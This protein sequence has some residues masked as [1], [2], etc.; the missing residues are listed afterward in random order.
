MAEVID[1]CEQAKPKTRAHQALNP[2]DNSPNYS[3][4]HRRNMTANFAALR[5]CMKNPDW[6]DRQKLSDKN[7]RAM[8]D[9]RAAE[10]LQLDERAA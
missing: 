8:V 1:F 4:E 5:H 3:P 9:S 7:A 2:P 10:L 6:G